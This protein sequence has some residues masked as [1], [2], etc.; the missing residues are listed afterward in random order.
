M[1]DPLGS[2]LESWFEARLKW[3]WR[4]AAAGSLG[5]TPAASSRRHWY[6]RCR[7]LEQE[8]RKLISLRVAGA[9]SVLKQSMSQDLSLTA[10]SVHSFGSFR[11]SSSSSSLSLSPNSKARASSA[12]SLP[13]LKVE[14]GHLPGARAFSFGQTRVFRDSPPGD[15]LAYTLPKTK[16]KALAE[17]WKDEST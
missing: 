14:L 2:T 17:D 12:G 5:C 3:S 13:V 11:K 15:L 10:S 9:R 7:V 16:P 8:V 6:D 1:M 4:R